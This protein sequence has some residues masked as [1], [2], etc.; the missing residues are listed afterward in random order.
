MGLISVGWLRV[1]EKAKLPPQ[2]WEG[3]GRSGGGQRVGGLRRHT[4]GG[5]G[6]IKG[7]V[8]SRIELSFH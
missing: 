3:G 2:D 1:T 4:R 6:G 7:F 5:A 8:V